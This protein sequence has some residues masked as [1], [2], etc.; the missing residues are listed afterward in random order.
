MPD[1]VLESYIRQC[2]EA[3]QTPLVNFAWQGGEPTLL[4]IQYFRKIVALQKRY[5]NGKTIENAFQTNGVL[6]NEDWA[7]FFVEN[8]FLIGVSIDGPH[9][10]HDAY[11]V[12]KGGQPTFDR[13]MRG[14]EVQQNF[15][16]SKASKLPA[17]CRSCDVRFACN[18]ECPK[19]R[20]LRTP[21]G[22][23]G[24]NCLCAAYKLFFRHVA[25][26]MR[27]MANQLVSERPPAAVMH[28]AAQQDGARAK[29]Q[30]GRNHACFAEA[31]RNL[32][33]AAASTSLV[34]VYQLASVSCFFL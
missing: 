1:D 20:F 22:E 18:G 10:L 26:Y 2:I 7:H 29:R 6:L 27:F 13:V 25:P 8:G 23:P 5:A 12:D 21:D 11:R 9:A 30:L 28:W 17:Y 4:G 34:L 3:Q 24:L 14:I 33:T 16:N 32:S 31:E 15:G 19:H